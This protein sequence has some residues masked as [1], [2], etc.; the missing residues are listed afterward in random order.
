[1]PNRFMPIN[2]GSAL[3]EAL[4]QI[5]KNFASLDQEAVTKKF[6]GQNSSD[7]VLI[8]KTGD[9]TAG[10]TITSGSNTMYVGKLDDGRFGMTMFDADGNE[11]FSGM[12]MDGRF[13]TIG[14]QAGVPVALRGMAPNDGR[15]GDWIVKPGLNVIDELSR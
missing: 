15:Q 6:G 13:A 11:V 10:M 3:Q 4:N 8:G 14:Y 2:P 12:Y 5:N 9:N 1:M 7:K